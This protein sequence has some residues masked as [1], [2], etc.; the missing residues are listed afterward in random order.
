MEELK[1]LIDAVAGLPKK[2]WAGPTKRKSWGE[3]MIVT[4]EAAQKSVVPVCSACWRLGWLPRTGKEAMSTNQNRMAPGHP[5]PMIPCTSASA[6]KDG[7]RLP[8]RAELVELFD[9]GEFDPRCTGAIL[10][11]NLIAPSPAYAWLVD[12]LNGNTYPG[13]AKF[14]FYV[15][16]VRSGQ[17]L[18]LGAA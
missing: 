16:L 4:Q 12:F 13:I 18:D 15:R 14:S 8:T 2:A 6:L 17:S 3:K 10:V 1:T 9:S 7:W 5:R 11:I